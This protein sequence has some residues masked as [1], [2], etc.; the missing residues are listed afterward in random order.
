M[1]EIPELPLELQ[2]S[3]WTEYRT[4][5]RARR[6]EYVLCLNRVMLDFI[7]TLCPSDADFN[8]LLDWTA[9]MLQHPSIKPRRGIVLVGTPGC[10]SLYADFVTLLLG[11]S[12]VWRSNTLQNRGFLDGDCHT[13]HAGRLQCLRGATPDE[14]PRL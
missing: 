12:N 4:G 8:R 3:I 11:E 14:Q 6:A 9:H 2:E 5:V 13:R 7:H 10:G 1:I